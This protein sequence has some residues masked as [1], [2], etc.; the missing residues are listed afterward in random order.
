MT[1]PSQLATLIFLTLISWMSGREVDLYLLGGQSNMQ[2][3]GKFINV[4]DGLLREFPDIRFFTGKQF[5]PLLPGQTRTSTRAGEFGPEIGFALEMGAV[6][7]PVYLVKDHHSGMGLHHGFDGGKWVG[8]EPAPS[9]RNFYPGTDA[10]DENQGVLYR[11]MLS[12]YRAAIAQL[13]KEGHEVVIRGWVWMQ[14]E[15][16]AKQAASARSYAAN[17]KHLRKRL[18]EDLG[19]SKPSDLPLVF[20]QVLPHEPA[21]DR[22]THRETIRAVMAQADGRSGSEKAL[23]RSA[24]VPTDGLGLLPDTVHFNAAGQLAL[25]R[26]FAKVLQGLLKEPG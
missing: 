21:A 18:A 16:D 11:L 19:L 5:E 4:D 1:R 9:R 8:G 7:R 2:G 12:R 10:H 15:Q 22:F 20:G 6:D 26:R 14:G 17:L 24:M 3:I 25:G 23:P 13:E